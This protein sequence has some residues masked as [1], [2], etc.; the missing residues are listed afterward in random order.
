MARLADRLMDLALAGFGAVSEALYPESGCGAPSHRDAAMVERGRLWFLT[1]PP[2][3]RRLL[4]T[5]F[6]SMELFGARFAVAP[7][8][9]SRLPV[10]RR[11]AVIERLRRSPLM[12][13]KLLG[14]SLKSATSMIYLSHPAVLAYLG[15]YKSCDHPG[16]DLVPYH[17]GALADMSPAGP[18]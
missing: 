7:G 8:R 1:L 15:V 14:D 6:A 9:F 17:P 16:E 4:L 10:A 13:L 3:S 11:L 2:E 5:L 12:P 18:T